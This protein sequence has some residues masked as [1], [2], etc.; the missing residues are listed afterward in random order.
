MLLLVFC[1]REVNLY[2]LSFE[3]QEY[4]NLTKQFLSEGCVEAT[5]ALAIHICMI[6]DL[7]KPVDQPYATS[8]LTNII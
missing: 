4:L 3:Y 5:F 8:D 6:K 2:H 1:I 7:Q